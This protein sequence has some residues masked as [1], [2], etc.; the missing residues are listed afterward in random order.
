MAGLLYLQASPRK[1]RSYCLRA[2][3]AFVEAYR[4]A[5]PGDEVSTI[6]LFQR[7]LIAFDGL[8]VQAKYTILHGRDHTDDE[9]AAW[10]A[11]EALIEEFKAADKYLLAAPMWNFSIP[12]RL[13]QYIDILVQPGYTFSYSPEQ[14]YRG[15]VLGRP[16]CICYSRGGDYSGDFASFDL[17]KKYLETI[18][19]FM[20]FTDLRSVV[21]EPTLMGGPEVAKEALD[22]GIDKARQIAGDF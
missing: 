21:I 3:D 19:G 6:N 22:S 16:I 18:F 8:A 15:L 5:H 10:G 9:A 4:Q 1:G 2:A 11:V 13:K 20:G 14:G 7:D 12:Y 17:Q